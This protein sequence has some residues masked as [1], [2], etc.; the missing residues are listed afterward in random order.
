VLVKRNIHKFLALMVASVFSFQSCATLI[1]RTSKK[2]PVT[3][4]PSGARI[5]VN[6]EEMGYTPLI[7]RLKR[8]KNHIIRVEKQGYNPLEIR[9]KRKISGSLALSI[10]GNI[11]IIG[12][13]CMAAVL[14]IGGIDA[15]SEKAGSYDAIGHLLF[16]GVGILFDTISGANFTPSPAELDV[17]LEKIKDKPQPD[18]TVI[19]SERFQNIKWIRIKLSNSDKENEVLFYHP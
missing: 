11:A 6:G 19:D 3:S 7:L 1:S 8:N 9:I 10:L 17:A 12:P 13:L 18:I 5:V 2:I 15:S 16:G 4:H 14:V